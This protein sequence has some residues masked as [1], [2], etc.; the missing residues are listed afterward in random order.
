MISLNEIKPYNSDYQSFV[1]SDKFTIY[2]TTFK[3]KFS[4]ED[5]IKRVEENKMLY[6][7]T[8]ITKNHSLEFNIECSEFKAIDNFFIE[9]LEEIDNVDV[10][11]ISKFSWVYTQTKSFSQQWMHAHKSLHRFNKSNISTQWVCVFYISVPTDMIASEGNLLF[12]TENDEFFS[13]AP[14][15]NDVVFFS[16]NI[17]HMTIPN[18]SSNDIRISYVS[19]FNFNLNNY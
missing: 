1:L 7:K 17:Q 18:Q 2:K 11:K 14:K 16:G 8:D 10:S 3:H 13:F 12:K 15:E 6:Y 4:K 19:N 5:L 9:S